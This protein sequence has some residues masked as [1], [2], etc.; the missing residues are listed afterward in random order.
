[1]KIQERDQK[2]SQKYRKKKQISDKEQK[3]KSQ[4][5]AKNAHVSTAS[6]ANRR[7]QNAPLKNRRVVAR[8]HR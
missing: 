4:L 1:M 2:K 3:N 8:R 7:K 6:K 5:R